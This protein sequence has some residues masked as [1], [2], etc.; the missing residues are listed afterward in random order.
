[1]EPVV[2]EAYIGSR[3]NT[4]RDLLKKIFI[5]AKLK[6]KYIDLLLDEDGMKLYSQIFTHP[7]IDPQNNYEFYEILGDSSANRSIVWY[8]SRRFPQLNCPEG[9]KIMARLK[10]HLV[11]KQ[12]FYTLAE[13]LGFWPFI[14]AT[15][16]ERQTKMKKILEDVFEA[17]IGA[18]ELMLDE[19][20]RR[21]VGNAVTYNI[22][23]SLFDD[24]EI[25]LDYNVLFDAKTR[26][27]EIF[28]LFSKRGIGKLEYESLRDDKLFNTVVFQVTPEGK[29]IQIGSAKASLKI[30]AEQRAAEVAIRTLAQ[31]GIS[32]P[33]PEEFKKFARK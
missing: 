22:I 33:V 24:L 20:I 15:V 2:Q 30:D 13:S 25:S 32:K 18:T 17:F 8:L 19:K 31:R 28:D 26:L 10:I 4:F 21:G 5:Q 27:K 23:A 16:D 9:V 29:R 14:S 3:D 1:M 7:S 11:S 12:T 6:A